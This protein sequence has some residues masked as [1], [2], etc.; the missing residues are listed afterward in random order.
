MDD[1][2]GIIY[3]SGTTGAPKGIVRSDLSMF[4]E[5]VGWCLELPI[6]RNSI[7]F[8]GRPVYYTGGLVLT[9]ATLLVGGS[10]ILPHEWSV[11]IYKSFMST[12]VVD[13]AFLIPDQVRELIRNHCCPNSR[14]NC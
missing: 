11:T 1:E 3:S 9:A 4:T 5:L 14:A 13:F 8:I 10:A 6:T 2:W 12:N 7:A